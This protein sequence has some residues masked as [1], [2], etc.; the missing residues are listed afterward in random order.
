MKSWSL[1]QKLRLAGRAER[2]FDSVVA[3]RS[4]PAGAHGRLLVLRLHRRRASPTDGLKTLAEQGR[5]R[6]PAAKGQSVVVSRQP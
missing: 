5:A 4:P 6:Q 1:T 2:S 3:V